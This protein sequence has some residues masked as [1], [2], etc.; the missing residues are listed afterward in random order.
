MVYQAKARLDSGIASR[1][2]ITAI[3]AV[4]AAP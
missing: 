3:E 1:V 2:R 4:R